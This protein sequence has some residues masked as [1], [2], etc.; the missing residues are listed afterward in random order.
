MLS[1]K[2]RLT[3]REDFSTVYSKGSYIQQDGFTAKYLQSGQPITRIGF[4]IGK[5]FSKRAVRRNRARRILQEACRSYIQTLKTGFDIV[6]ILKPGQE[7]IEFKKVKDV[8]KQIFTK[9]NL[10]T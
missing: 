1:K 7:N 8:L 4:S 9:A 6:I 10:F 2:H 5:N 3:K